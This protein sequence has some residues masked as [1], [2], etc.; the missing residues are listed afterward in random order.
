MQIMCTE[1]SSSWPNAATRCTSIR[2]WP[3]RRPHRRTHR[4]TSRRGNRRIKNAFRPANKQTLRTE[5][6]NP[7]FN[8]T[9]PTSVT[10]ATRLA[11]RMRTIQHLSRAVLCTERWTVAAAKRPATGRTRIIGHQTSI[12]DHCYPVPNCATWI[13]FSCW[14]IRVSA[15]G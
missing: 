5:Q 7:K 14:T 11:L 9:P 15:I 2:V 6:I 4:R 13:C 1:E 12:F 8:W 3:H 10:S